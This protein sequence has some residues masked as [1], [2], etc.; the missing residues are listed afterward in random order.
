[1]KTVMFRIEGNPEGDDVMEVSYTT[2][3]GGCSHALYR[4][5][6]ETARAELVNGEPVKVVEPKD[7]VEVIASR[8]A[9]VIN[10]SKSEYSANQFTARSF[11]NTLVISCSD[12]VD[13]VTFLPQVQGTGSATIKEI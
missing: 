3:R 1:M 11:G 4:V 10:D 2:P 13:N 5:K 12:S 6:G 9:E 8:L 7:T